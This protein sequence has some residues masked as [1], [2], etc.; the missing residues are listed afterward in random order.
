MPAG[1]VI[2]IFFWLVATFAI[3][4][5][6]KVKPL[7]ETPP[8]DAV[9]KE[10]AAQLA[11]SGAQVSSGSK[12]LCDIWLC[13]TLPTKAD[14][15][16]TEETLYPLQPGQLV[17]VVR[18]KSKGADFRDQEIPRGVYTLRYA[19]QP[20]DGNHVGTSPTRDFLVLLAAKEDTSPKPLEEK[21]MFKQ[22]AESI[23]TK[24]PAMLCLQRADSAKRPAMR[25]IED[26]AWS[27][28][29]LS[30]AGE[31]GKMIDLDFVVVG[32]ATE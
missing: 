6:E 30:T 13:K 28:I 2:A 17:G 9:S 12:T 5:D 8:A 23:G 19:L 22:S 3:A 24:H 4:A 14:F 29:Q 31:G 16:P 21:A 1:R 20:V 27:I 11:T 26:P 25:H 10:V 15:K 32:H 18:Y 7:A